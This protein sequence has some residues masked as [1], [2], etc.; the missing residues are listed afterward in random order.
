M[1][2]ISIF[3]EKKLQFKR[4]GSK[5]R[6]KAHSKRS[7]ALSKLKRNEKRQNGEK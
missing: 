4:K 3:N 2:E 1:L 7:K 6:K 5:K